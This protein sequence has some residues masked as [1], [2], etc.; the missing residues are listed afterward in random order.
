MQQ[1]S[2]SLYVKFEKLLYLRV[3]KYRSL[4]YNMHYV[5]YD[6]D[7][8]YLLFSYKY[9]KCQAYRSKFILRK[10]FSDDDR[11][12]PLFIFYYIFI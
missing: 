6:S 4:A 3:F 11:K 10:P 8:K 5:N 7:G 9:I 1:V 2:K 12:I